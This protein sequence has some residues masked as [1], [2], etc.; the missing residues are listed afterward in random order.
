MKT[1]NAV[2]LHNVT[3]QYTLHHEKPT[4][5]EHLF[6]G[7]HE[8][9]TALHGIDLT[10]KNGQKLGII[11][12]NGSGKTTLLK[13]IAGITTPTSGTVE[14]RGMLVSLIDIEAGFHPDLTGE[15]NIYL[16]GMIMGM[17]KREIDT[18]LDDII[19]FSEIGRFID[20]PLFTYSSGMILRLGFAVAVHS[21]PDIL[22]LDEGMDAGDQFFQKKAAARFRHFLHEV[23]TII[24]VSHWLD[25][26]R[27]NCDSVII[28]NNGEITHRGSRK[29]ISTYERQLNTS[30][31]PVSSRL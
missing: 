15:Q 2:E 19:S 11:G 30:H 29:L 9:F 6:H 31:P 27:K 5:V 8:R 28:M 24:V 20:A 21:K 13:I 14:S 25:I 7:K 18:R 3:K 12:A 17:T 4:L 26:V 10:I 22:L 1:G 23:R 16:N